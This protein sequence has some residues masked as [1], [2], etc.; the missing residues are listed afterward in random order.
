MMDKQQNHL[1]VSNNYGN[2]IVIKA[3]SQAPVTD[4]AVSNISRFGSKTAV[5]SLSSRKSI[6][7]KTLPDTCLGS[8]LTIS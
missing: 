1:E 8:I 2:N 6:D 7:L 4:L 5:T 3:T